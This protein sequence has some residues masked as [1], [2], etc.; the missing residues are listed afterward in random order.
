MVPSIG[1]QSLTRRRTPDGSQDSGGH[2]PSWAATRENF[3]AALANTNDMERPVTLPFEV[4]P[5]EVLPF[6]VRS[7][8][9][10]SFEVRSFEVRRSRCVVRGASFEVRSFELGGQQP[11]LE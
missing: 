1:S 3:S 11:S 2:G 4:L 8:E 9:V 5:F 7:F 6:E 10:R